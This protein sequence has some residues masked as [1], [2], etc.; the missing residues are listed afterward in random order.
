MISLIL[1]QLL[2]LFD[3][4]T[5]VEKTLIQTLASQLSCNSCSRFT[6]TEGHESQDRIREIR[7][8]QFDVYGKRETQ[9]F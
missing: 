4:D 7:D 6:R 2:F 8:L 3:Q 9:T 1:M 5:K